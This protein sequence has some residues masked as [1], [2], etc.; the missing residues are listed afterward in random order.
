MCARNKFYMFKDLF[1]NVHGLGI[2]DEV[3]YLLALFSAVAN[4]IFLNSAMTLGD[5][6]IKDIRVLNKRKESIFVCQAKTD[7]LNHVLPYYEQQTWNFMKSIVRLGDIC[8]DIGA[9]IGAYTI[10][11]ARIVGSKGLVIAIEPSPANVI[12]EKNVKINQLENVIIVNKAVFSE[13]T[14]LSL[15]FNGRRTGV[16]SVVFLKTNHKTE[17]EAAPLDEILAEVLNE[18]KCTSNR[19]KLIKIDVEGAEEH[20]LKGGLKT[21]GLVDYIIVE[22]IP[23]REPNATNIKRLLIER[24]FKLIATLDEI[25]LVFRYQS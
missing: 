13:R 10:P 18:G 17:V 8:V 3:S 25:N 21:L 6:L 4:R 14:R 16:S 11:L 1:L 22:V 23:Q 12:L 7:E 20:V 9:H 19:I 2:I 15:S 5:F 24:G